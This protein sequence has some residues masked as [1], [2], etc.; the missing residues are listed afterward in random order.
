VLLEVDGQ[1]LKRP[2]DLLDTLS[3]AGTGTSITFKVLRGGT[4]KTV[5]LK[6]ADRG[7]RT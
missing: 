2:A 1:A 3:A 7:E 6:P 4:V 5:S